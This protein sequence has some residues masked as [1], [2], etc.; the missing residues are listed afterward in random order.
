MSKKGT[1]TEYAIWPALSAGRAQGRSEKASG[2]KCLDSFRAKYLKACQMP[3][4]S[5]MVTRGLQIRRSGSK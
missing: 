2:D 1:R 3:V 4:E 5:F